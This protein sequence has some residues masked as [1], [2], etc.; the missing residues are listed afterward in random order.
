MSKSGIQLWNVISKFKPFIVVDNKYYSPEL[1]KWCKFKLDTDNVTVYSVIKEE[2][3]NDNLS[4]YILIDN[5]YS[6]EYKK[7]IFIQSTNVNE[8]L[9]KLLQH[10]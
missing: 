10:L 4:S 8:T 9:H 7:Q 1:F 2:E 5:N 3:T 6:D